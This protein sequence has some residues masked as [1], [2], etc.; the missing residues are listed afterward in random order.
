MEGWRLWRCRGGRGVR[1]GDNYEPTGLQVEGV[2][3]KLC[4]ILQFVV[5][6]Q[7]NVLCV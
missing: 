2:E 5:I 1:G 7:G 3:G 6:Y 4:L